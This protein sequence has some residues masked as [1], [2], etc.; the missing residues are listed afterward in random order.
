MRGLA[1]KNL[2]S[3]GQLFGYFTRNGYG[4]GFTE[5]T[6]TS[7]GCEGVAVGG[8]AFYG[9]KHKVA[10]ARSRPSPGGEGGRLKSPAH[11]G[12]G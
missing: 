11:V 6:S 4:Y 8:A 9:L 2:A 5:F 3:Q 12:A 10:C 7:L 1:I